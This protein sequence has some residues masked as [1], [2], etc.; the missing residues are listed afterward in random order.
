[1]RKRTA[2]RSLCRILAA[3]LL[4]ALMLFALASC[5]T[6]PIS[7][8]VEYT[9]GD[10]P[11]YESASLEDLRP[12]LK[13][14]ALGTVGNWYEITDYTLSG[15]LCAGE[16]TVTVARGILKDSF[17]VSVTAVAPVSLA[18]DFEQE[19]AVY[20]GASLDSLREY[21]TVSVVN[22]DGSRAE[23]DNYTLSGELRAGK[24]DITV[25]CGELPASFTVNVTAVE[26]VSIKAVF[27]GGEVSVNSSLDYLKNYLK[28]TAVNN[29]GSE[30][31]VT[32]YSLYGELALGNCDVTV[33]YGT[34]E[35]VF[36]VTVTEVFD[37]GGVKLEYSAD[38]GGYVVVDYVGSS[39]DVVIPSDCGG[40]PVVSVGTVFAGRGIASIA[41]PATVLRIDARAFLGCT[42]LRSVTLLG[43]EAI[44]ERAF[45]GCSSLEAVSL[46]S[47]VR[48]IGEYAFYSCTSLLSVTVA[49]N[50]RLVSVGRSAFASCTKLSSLDF[51]ESSS[52]EKIAH[53]AFYNCKSLESLTIPKSVVEIGS[54]AFEYCSSLNSLSVENGGGLSS[55]GASAFNGCTSLSSVSFGSDSSLSSLG[56]HAFASCTSLERITL[57]ASLTAIG[58]AAFENC[59]VLVEFSV[60][61]GN[62][63][64]KAIG[65]VLYSADGKT[66]VAYPAALTAQ[67]FEIP[68]GVTRIGDYAFSYARYLKKAVIPDTVETVG[69]KAF[70]YALALVEI[71]VGESVTD[72]GNSAF[73][74]CPKLKTVTFANGSS[75]QSIKAYTF[76]ECQSLTSVNLPASLTTIG[77][78][79]FYACTSLSEITVPAAVNLIADGVFA[80]CTSLASVTFEKTSGWIVSQ[81]ADGAGG[82]PVSTADKAKNAENLKGDYALHYW[83]RR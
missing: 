14:E 28:I 66:L 43:G 6:H 34:L 27:S 71:T 9:G 17:T 57:P 81:S 56:A 32:D 36:A 41:I 10:T 80:N 23:T 8:R 5:G 55:L 2:T 60:E 1:M 25:K 16:S 69:I 49:D 12:S 47:S 74:C 29:D 82:T 21:L 3:L 4:C 83:I 78:Y 51:G 45:Y 40:L 77:P 76:V 7:V 35:A 18:L 58:G 30:T 53:A 24:S 72:L 50:S 59:Q 63:G 48:E 75:L 65:G 13:V 79:A 15:E 52:L 31:A 44:G 68:S 39:A 11:V 46:P 73:F 20:A 70:E 64:F 54:S 26:P 42:S 38:E 61:A 22:N 67:T 33:K 37:V 19:G 62:E